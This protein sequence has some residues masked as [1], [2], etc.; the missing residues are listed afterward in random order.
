LYARGVLMLQNAIHQYKLKKVAGTYGGEYA[1][2]CPSCGGTDRF[3]IWPEKGRFWCRGCG[4]KG[5]EVDFLRTFEGLSFKE[6]CERTGKDIAG[7]RSSDVRSRSA[8]EPRA[9]EPREAAWQEKAEAFIRWAQDR[10]ADVLPSLL[11]RGISEETARRF[12]LGGC[13]KDLWRT[14]E[15]W[16]LP[17]KKNDQGKSKKLWIP[18]GLVIPYGTP[19]ERIRIRRPEG[20]PRYY[21]LPGSGTA[22]M[23]I[24]GGGQAVV[25]V[26]SELDAMLIHQDAGE[27]VDVAALGNAQARPDTTAVSFLA[28][29][30]ILV[31]LDSDQAGAKEAWNWWSRHFPK[32][33]RWIPI[34][35]K[36]PSE[37]K[38]NGLNLKEWIEVGLEEQRAKIFPIRPAT[39]PD[40]RNPEDED[41]LT[42]LVGALDAGA[43]WRSISTFAHKELTTT[44]FQQLKAEYEVREPAKPPEWQSP[45]PARCLDCEHQEGCTRDARGRW[46]LCCLHDCADFARKGSGQC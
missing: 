46:G 43:S 17:E 1:G 15:A 25:I 23:L 3:H 20:E 31:A 10:L 22:A 11:D 39:K 8:W 44:V 30:K 16:G 18:A 5:D 38:R 40:E 36:D 12:R 28:G 24:R 34:R 2:P 26:E 14:C 45:Y 9:I 35:G 19:V 37:S 6:A 7:R 41:M 42:A 21:L 29:K 32:A 13:P 4:L 27:L 33:K